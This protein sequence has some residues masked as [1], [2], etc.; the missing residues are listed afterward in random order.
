MSLAKTALMDEILK[1]I[2]NLR[3]PHLF[4]NVGEIQ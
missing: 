3:N 1:P 4:K 2:K